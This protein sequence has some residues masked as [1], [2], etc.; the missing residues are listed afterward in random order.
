MPARKITVANGIIRHACTVMI[1]AI[2]A[3]GVPSQV[4]G[5]SGEIRWSRAR[6]QFKM[7]ACG[8]KNQ[9]KPIV[10]RAIGAAHGRRMRNRNVQRPRK[11]RMSACASSPATTTTTSCEMT[12]NRTVCQTASRN[13]ESCNSARKFPRP[14]QRPLSEPAV[15]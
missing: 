2:A 3:R 5:L 10:V 15:A 9:R 4:G 11:L 7:L 8:S 12:V 1:E 13:T 14:T 6:N